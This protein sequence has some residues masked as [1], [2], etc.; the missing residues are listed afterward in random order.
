MIG[1]PG[2]GPLFAYTRESANELLPELQVLLPEL[3]D[4]YATLAGIAA[5]T[6]SLARHNGGTAQPDRRVA[7]EATVARV[8]AWLDARRILLKD[9]ERGL[10]DFPAVRD[11]RP[12]LLCWQLGEPAVDHWHE[13]SEGF[14]GRQ[15]L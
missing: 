10:V 1:M 2:S 14:A 3:R 11:G 8:V 13:V 12:V 6:R 15:R 9:I 5:T 7:A 4:A